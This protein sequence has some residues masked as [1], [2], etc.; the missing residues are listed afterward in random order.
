VLFSY[1]IVA[2]GGQIRHELVDGHLYISDIE[3]AKRYVQTVPAQGV[4]ADA[5]LEVILY[6]EKGAEIWRGPYSGAPAP[7][8]SGIN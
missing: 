3:A 8:S 4:R 1:R 7:I 6:D 2:S 5:G